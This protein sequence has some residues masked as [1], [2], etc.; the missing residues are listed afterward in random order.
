MRGTA[1]ILGLEVRQLESIGNVHSPR[2]DFIVEPSRAEEAYRAIW[3]ALVAARGDWDVLRLCQLPSDSPTLGELRRLAIAD[4]F[5]V[6]E[7]PAGASPY[8]RVQGT[9]DAYE[10][11]LNAKH[12][13]NLRQKERRLRRI[14]A[15]EHQVI[16][17]SAGVS[18]V[19]E[20]GFRI[21][22][23]AWKA[24]AGTA[25]L[26]QAESHRFYAELAPR[27]MRRGWLRLSFLAVNG[28]RIAF[29]YCLDYKRKLFLLKNGYDPEYACHSPFNQLCSLE[30]R[31]AFDRGAIEFD[32]L[33]ESED[34]KLRWAP[35]A[36]SHSWLYV[37]PDGKL[38]RLIHRV[39]FRVFP[40]LQKR[41][42]FRALRG[43][44]LRTIG[45]SP[46]V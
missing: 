41:R 19:L 20:E 22:A 33:G 17:E 35:L 36:K 23:A 29:S 13:T 18:G 43:R 5:L 31:E 42:A 16:G 34:W 45:G 11:S 26:S 44:F 7:W 1:R 21:E 12:R 30:L 15:P 4:G 6:G 14:G 40:A 9:W 25:I 27:A 3:R 46:W 2:F 38:A 8:V 10:R 28:K 37:L 24:K 39:K 32:F